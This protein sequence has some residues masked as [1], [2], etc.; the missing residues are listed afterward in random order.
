MQALKKF[1]LVYLADIML[2]LL[3]LCGVGIYAALPWVLDAYIKYSYIDRGIAVLQPEVYSTM[4]IILYCSGI[5]AIALLVFAF[6]ITMNITRNKPFIMQNARSLNWMGL[7]SVLISAVFFVGSFFLLS[8]FPIIIC[9]IFLLLAV[10]AKVFA[11]LFRNAVL[12][13]EENDLTI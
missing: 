11:E 2:G 6:V 1:R 9:V 5:P 7:C 4:L 10:L 13:K 8:V 3:I 12:F